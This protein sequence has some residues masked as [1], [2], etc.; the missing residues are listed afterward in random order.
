VVRLVGRF[1]VLAVV[2]VVAWRRVTPGAMGKGSGET[3]ITVGLAGSGL[4][5]PGCL[6][7]S[8]PRSTRRA[9]SALGMTTVPSSVREQPLSVIASR[10]RMGSLGICDLIAG[11]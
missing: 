5:R 6:R 10:K 1:A 7:S 11:M 4:K 2:T 9:S 8:G 3:A